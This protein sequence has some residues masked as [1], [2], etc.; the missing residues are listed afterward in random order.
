MSTPSIDVRQAAQSV[1]IELRAQDDASGLDEILVSAEKDGIEYLIPA[2]LVQGSRLDG[3][4]R[5]TWSL[6]PCE[7]AAG[8][9]SVQPLQ[10]TDRAGNI[11][12]GQLAPRSLAVAGDDR[13]PPSY[14]ATASSKEVRLDFT[15][16][17]VGVTPSNQLLYFPLGYRSSMTVPVTGGSWRCTAADGSATDCSTGPLLTATFTPD[18]PLSPGWYDVE[19]NPEHVLDLT[20]LAGNPL[21]SPPSPSIQISSP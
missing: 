2:G 19:V 9:W 4:W 15:E 3:T 7:D 6:G 8:A 14:T 13:R 5:A 20:D 21:L 12:R 10:V 18:Q 1:V 17:V 11:W 16:N